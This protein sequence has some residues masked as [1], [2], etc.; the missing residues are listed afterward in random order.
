MLLIAVQ[1]VATAGHSFYQNSTISE[2]LY[3]DLLSSEVRWHLLYKNID[4]N[5]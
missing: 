4:I 1:H 2:F 3:H 5:M